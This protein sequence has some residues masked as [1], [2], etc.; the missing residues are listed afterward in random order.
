M[1]ERRLLKMAK[2]Y[3]SII[4]SRL[5]AELGKNEYFYYDDRLFIKIDDENL[6]Y[7]GKGDYTPC[8]CLNHDCLYF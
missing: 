1:S 7:N 2:V 4:N 5:I 6:D 8:L 3:K